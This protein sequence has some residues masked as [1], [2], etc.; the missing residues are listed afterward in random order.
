M[1]LTRE[2]MKRLH[3]RMVNLSNLCDDT[4]FELR[5]VI[6]GLEEISS[7]TQRLRSLMLAILVQEQQGSS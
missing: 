5:H 2:E 6:D 4:T 1:E 7:E 3:S